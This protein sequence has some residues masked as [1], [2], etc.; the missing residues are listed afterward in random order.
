MRQRKKEN[1]YESCRGNW[2]RFQ[3]SE[4]LR[5]V[6]F[7]IPKLS[8]RKMIDFIFMQIWKFISQ[9]QLKHISTMYRNC[10]YSSECTYTSSQ[11]CK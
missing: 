10:Q 3:P 7:K 11:K 8:R 4:K 9:D 5:V 2:L 6:N 1:D